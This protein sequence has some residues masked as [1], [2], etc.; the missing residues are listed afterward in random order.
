MVSLNAVDNKSP[1]TVA[2]FVIKRVAELGVPRKIRA[3]KG[4]ENVHVKRF[5]TLLRDAGY[6]VIYLEGVSTRNQRIE[7]W[8]GDLCPYITPIASAL[9]DMGT[10]GVLDMERADH[11]A[12]LHLVVLPYVNLVLEKAVAAW[13]N[14]RVSTEDMRCTPGHKCACAEARARARGTRSPH[15]RLATYSHVQHAPAAPPHPGPSSGP[16]R[17]RQHLAAQALW[18]LRAALRAAWLVPRCC[19]AGRAHRPRGCG[20]ERR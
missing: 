7:R 17:Q 1:E 5:V 4:G 13:N 15:V 2:A 14:H 16:R 19:G 3:D 12:A 20:C 11:E 9:Q 6:K 18:P 10:D 8:W